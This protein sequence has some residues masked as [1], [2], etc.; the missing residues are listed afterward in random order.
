MKTIL[1]LVMLSNLLMAPLF[2]KQPNILLIVSEDNGPELGCYGD[3]NARTPNLDRLATEGIRFERAFVPQAGCSQ[4]RASFLTGLYPHQHGQI[5]LATWNF[6]LYRED[7]PNL[8]RS[9]KAVG[10]RTGIIGKLHINP[11]SAFPFDFH[12]IPGANFGRKNLQDYAK[13]ASEFINA[14]EAPFF[15]SVNYPDPHDPWVRQVDGLPEVPQTGAD[16]RAMPY[17]GIDPPEGREMIADYYNCISRMDALVGDL[18]KVLEKSGKTR[19]TIVVYFG[20]H[21]ADMLRGKRTCYEGGLRIPLLMRWP[22]HV[23]AQVRTEM[24]STIDLM[25]TLLAAAATKPVPEMPGRAW[26]P[27]F[28]RGIVGWRK[29][30]FAEYHTHGATNFFPQRSVRNDRFK[31]I[32]NLLPG[33]VHPDYE[34]TLNK[35]TGEVRNSSPDVDLDFHVPIAQAPSEVK[36]A[37]ERMR[38]PPRYELY[39]LENDPFE[40]RNLADN[41]DY[42]K[43]L[44]ELVDQVNAW[45]RQTNDPLLQKENLRRLTEEVRSVKTK[46]ESKKKPWS[47]PDY[48]FVSSQEA[49]LRVMNVVLFLIDDLGWMDLACQ[50]SEYYQ[51]PNIDG[52]AREGARFTDAYAACAVCS[53]TRAALLTG[54][55][56]ARLLLTDWL[57]SGRWNP[58]AKLREGRRVRALPVEEHTLAEALREAGYKTASIG[59]WHLGSEPFSLPQHHGFDLNVAGNGHGAPGNYF[60]PYNGNWLIPTTGLLVKWNTLSDGQPGEYLTDRLTDE[61][62]NFLH[63]CKDQPFFLYFPHYGVHMP[64]HAKKEMIARY[65]RIP[66]EQRQGN[67]IY[68]AMVE[69]IDQSVGRVLAT[70]K[71]LGRDEETMIIFTSD[72]GGFYKATRN[73]PLRANKGSYYEGGIRVPLIIKWPG[74]TKPGSVIHEP[75]TSSDLYPTCLEAAGQPLLP[76]QHQDGLSLLPLL[77]GERTLNRD[78]I[79]WHFPH[80][81]QHPS[82]YPSSVIRRGSW[83]LIETFDP[84]GIELYNLKEDIGETSNLVDRHPDITQSLQHQ[85]ENWRLRVGAQRMESN[86]DY[87]STDNPVQ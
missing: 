86:P 45:R 7:T 70:L 5:G 6:R 77:Q 29:Y 24:V 22:G 43:Q 15:L 56:P 47:Y 13:H 57:P 80:Y 48:F 87:D 26:Q 72:N 44:N 16:V 85:L 32:E 12:E 78:A 76:N 62:V 49:E 23:Q 27:L 69:S 41:S 60:Y 42:E 19:D 31:L 37:Y 59:K 40:F 11:A 46:K 65:E 14:D 2:A 33:E 10:Y 73:A 75:V 28:Q 39:D 18:L 9:L 17:M 25:P 36:K 74:V 50:G 67:P 84:E 34:A 54:K 20:D 30:L 3:P 71:E 55:Y 63:S 4:S 58:R 53:P 51:T 82:S 21:G 35:M 1:Y 79:F 68:A 8:P 61:A 66:E 52:L 64:L 81:N 38:Q 83:K